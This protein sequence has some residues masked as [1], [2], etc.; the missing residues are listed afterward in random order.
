MILNLSF[1]T[2][3]STKFIYL[4]FVF[5]CLLL[6]GC[7]TTHIPSSIKKEPESQL[8]K[9]SV[10]S[11]RNVELVKVDGKKVRL[12]PTRSVYLL[13]GNHELLV[14]VYHE[15]GAV[16]F[17]AES[18]RSIHNGIKNSISFIGSAGEHFVIELHSDGRAR[19]VKTKYFRNR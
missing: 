6:T 8:I 13:P 14:L 15:S 9:L 2:F 3:T 4:S 12:G 10:S 11:D 18:G 5:L 19:L 17:K 16:L 7:V 1:K